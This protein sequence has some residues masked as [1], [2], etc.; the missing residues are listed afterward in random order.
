MRARKRRARDMPTQRGT[1]G[2]LYTFVSRG[3]VSVGVRVGGIVVNGVVEADRVEICEDVESVVDV[4]GVWEV[5]GTT[6][7]RFD[8]GE[9]EEGVVDMIVCLEVFGFKAASE[10]VVEFDMR[11]LCRVTKSCPQILGKS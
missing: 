9:D 1:I 3:G 5:M 10:V 11:R 8:V 2:N 4:V 6:V 7:E